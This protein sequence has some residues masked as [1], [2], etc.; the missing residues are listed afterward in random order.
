MMIARATSLLPIS[1]P[2]PKALQPP[3]TE[4]SC[5]GRHCRLPARTLSAASRRGTA[6]LEGPHCF[7]A[8]IALR[9]LDRCA[10]VC[11]H[12]VW[13]GSGNQQKLRAGKVQGF[14]VLRCCV[15]VGVDGNEQR[16]TALTVTRLERCTST[17]ECTDHSSVPHL[18][19]NM[20]GRPP[21]AGVRPSYCV[22]SMRD[23]QQLFKTLLVAA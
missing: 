22:F 10:T 15:N 18:G 9:Y 4:F 6:I 17:E 3:N 16:R 11:R 14:V 8:T 2:L 13:R 1:K 19:R 5:K 20:E 21:L 23:G 12:G 7:R